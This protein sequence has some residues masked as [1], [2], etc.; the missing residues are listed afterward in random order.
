MNQGRPLKRS[1]NV[2]D[3]KGS[4]KVSR[5]DDDDDDVDLTW[6]GLNGYINLLIPSGFF[7]YLQD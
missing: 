4:K 3:W 7:T 6:F 2:R 1:L 5:D